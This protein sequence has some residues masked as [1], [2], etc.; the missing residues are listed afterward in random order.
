MTALIK[1]PDLQ[2]DKL[3]LLKNEIFNTLD[4]TPNSRR[5][6][7]TRISK[8]LEFVGI[9]G[10]NR[11]SYLEYKRFLRDNDRLSVAT[12]NKYL[13]S[14]KVF[15]DG[16][17]RLQLIPIKITDSIKGFS[18]SRLH[19]KN[20]LTDSDI[21]TIQNYCLQLEPTPQNLR[22]KAIFALLIFQGLRQIEITRLD[23]TDI[24]L[25]ER[26]AAI[27]GKGR[28]D[29]EPIHLHPT[30]VKLL[31]E[32][33][34]AIQF[35]EGALFRSSSNF[36]NSSRLTTKSIREIVT[37]TLRE[38]GIDGTTHGFRHFFITK[39]IKSYK[40]ELLTVSK[41]SRHRSIQM[42]EVYNDEIIREEDLPRFYDVFN[43]IEL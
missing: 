13:I 19:K 26:T 3:H 42:L 43:D 14:A 25:K 1:P 29:K 18:Q 9:N 5:D 21:T 28:D 6:Y 38:L 33:M 2:L 34:K 41:Y 22:L 10:L 36:S 11:N 24:N 27:R 8:F 37:H 23:V 7:E 32:Y 16:L 12:K 17:Y 39:L 40:G 20:G 35:R 4:I 15:L 30:T 31:K